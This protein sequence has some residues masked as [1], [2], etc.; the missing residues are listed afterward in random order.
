MRRIYLFGI[1]YLLLSLS[2]PVQAQRYLS[3]SVGTG[4][5]YYY[6][7]LAD[8]FTNLFIRPGV[9]VGA[10][11]YVNPFVRT[12]MNFMYTTIGSADSAA[13]EIERINRNLHFRST[14]MEFSGM[15]YWEILQDKNYKYYWRKKPHF[16]P[17]VFTGI[18]LFKFNPRAQLNGE[19]HDL[20]PLGTEGQYLSGPGE[21]PYSLWE[22]AIPIGVGA[23]YRFMQW[24][25]VEFEMAYRKTFTDY[26]D[27]V[28]TN[29]PDQERMLNEIGPVAAALSDRALV[30]TT[31]GGKRGNPSA[32]DG[33]FFMAFSVTVYLG[34]KRFL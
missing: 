18:S 2:Q 34:N 10:S 26:L 13:N 8:R 32:K 1:L 21:E 9:N 33:Y 16:T 24:L 20:Q 22:I 27:D 4:I 14:L 3:L 28:S 11:Y 5:S 23:S 15:V 25:G 17:Y 12:K 29:Y 6:G 30:P 7:D 31:T 19:W